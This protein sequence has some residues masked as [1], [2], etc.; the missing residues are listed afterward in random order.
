MTR[1][2]LQGI[3]KGFL[4]ASLALLA[5]GFLFLYSASSQK[6]A[7][8]G[9]SFVGRQLTWAGIGLA[10]ALLLVQIDY[11]RWLEWAYFLYGVNVLLLVL[12]LE[13]GVTRG[14]AQRWLT[15]GGFTVQPSEFAK[16][17]TL[18]A[19]ARYLGSRPEATVNPWRVL[20]WAGLLTAVPMA[21]IL[22]EP[23]LGTAC[24]FIPIFLGVALVWGM[25]LKV[26]GILLAVFS[27]AAPLAWWHIADYQK[28]RLMVFMNPDLDP[29]GAGYTVVQSKIA[30]GS[31]GLW[32][33]GWLAGSQNQLNFL[34]E[35][36]TDFIFSVVGEEW[37]FL[38]TSVCLGLLTYL[39]VRGLRLAHETRDPFGRLLT[40]GLIAM[41][42]FHTLV[43]T[44]MT[45][46]VMPVVGLPL[47]FL[48]YGGSWLLTVCA[49]V[50][51]VLSVGAR[52]P[53]Y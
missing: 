10:A 37:G 51:M 16:V 35:R 20:G 50:G 34:P 47:P 27:A 48:S 43:N 44:G 38:G 6:A 49:A 2:E 19:L 24:V 40:V 1:R 3:D 42:A 30:I 11:H 53:T 26:L 39:F 31:G 46:G 33:K 29:L 9:V 41:L 23:N 45:M 36:H 18:L 25:R 14:G 32:G 5:L 12:V 7:A 13:L 17:T 52:R 21:L 15:V 4:L 28:R 22:M 8:L